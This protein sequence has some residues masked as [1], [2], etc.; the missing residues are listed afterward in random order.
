MA[1]FP[2]STLSPHKQ[3]SHGQLGPL[4]YETQWTSLFLSFSASL[5][6]FILDHSFWKTHV[7]PSLYDTKL[8]W[9]HCYF[10]RLSSCS[11]LLLNLSTWQLC[12]ARS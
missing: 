8:S 1:P 10:F 5:Q 11:P 7:S 6:H 12:W 4:D 9:F 2:H 3:L